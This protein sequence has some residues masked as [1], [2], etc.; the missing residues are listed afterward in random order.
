LT[1]SSSSIVNPGLSGAI[2]AQTGS[3]RKEKRLEA[4]AHIFANTPNVSRNTVLQ[5]V[6]TLML[7]G[8]L[9]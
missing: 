5:A 7:A 1:I 4:D 2:L 6:E 3:P 9:A 8:Y